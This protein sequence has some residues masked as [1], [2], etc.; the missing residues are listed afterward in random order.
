MGLDGRHCLPLCPRPTLILCLL[1]ASSTETLDGATENFHLA[2]LS[3]VRPRRFN[4]LQR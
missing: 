1:N 4:R 2:V 3:C